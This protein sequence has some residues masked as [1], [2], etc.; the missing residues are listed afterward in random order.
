MTKCKI[1]L[2][3]VCCVCMCDRRCGCMRERERKR[4]FDTEKHPPTH[5]H[6]PGSTVTAVLAT[7]TSPK[8]SA[9]ST[10]VSSN[11][12]HAELIFLGMT[13]CDERMLVEKMRQ[14]GWYTMQYIMYITNGCAPTP[15]HPP[16]L[17][18]ILACFAGPCGGV[19]QPETLVI[20]SSQQVRA[21]VGKVEAS[22]NVGVC[23]GLAV[24]SQAEGNAGA[25]AVGW[26]RNAVEHV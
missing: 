19:P 26:T 6:T 17:S 7:L 20:P 8:R 11:V 18:Y 14:Q 3:W 16:T 13:L 5:K 4:E 23:V 12:K 21:I 24:C 25:G 2:Y 1:G 9:M 10:S 15:M 22:Y